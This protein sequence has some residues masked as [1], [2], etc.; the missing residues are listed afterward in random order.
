[1]ALHR[2]AHVTEAI[3]QQQNETTV[4]ADGAAATN[5]IPVSGIKVGDE[6]KRV[7]GL[8]GVV[9]YADYA[10]YEPQ[11]FG[12]FV[13]G[14]SAFAVD[15]YVSVNG[16]F[17]IFSD[18]TGQSTDLNFP[19]GSNSSNRYFVPF[20][21]VAATDLTALVASINGA[22]TTPAGGQLVGVT[23]AVNG[24]DLDLVAAEYGAAGENV[25]LGFS[26]DLT[27]AEWQ[28]AAAATA[29]TLNLAAGDVEGILSATDDS[30][31][32]GVAG[33]EVTFLPYVNI[34]GTLDTAAEEV[35]HVVGVYKPGATGKVADGIG[36]Y[37]DF[38]LGR[39]PPGWRP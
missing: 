13:L 7:F 12:K 28:D 35:V 20:A 31:G 39:L 16:L 11:A 26:A 2:R 37:A 19:V 4:L 33:L 24:T 32:E 8:V 27:L 36:D 3:A 5:V 6:L 29:T 21:G 38:G 10:V 23:A 14:G 34:D 17:F 25:E 18:R 22:Y 9:D 1:M 30:S 15:S